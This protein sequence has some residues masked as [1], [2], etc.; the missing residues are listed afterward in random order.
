MIPV[1]TRCVRPAHRL[2]LAAPVKL[3]R[4]FAV[5][6]KSSES[7]H[8]SFAC[9]LIPLRI[10]MQRLD[11]CQGFAKLWGCRGQAGSRPP[12]TLPPDRTLASVKSSPSRSLPTPT[13]WC[14]SR[15]HYRRQED[16]RSLCGARGG[17]RLV[18]R[19]PLGQRV[20]DTS[21]LIWPGPWHR[22]P[23]MARRARTPKAFLN[24]EPT[25]ATDKR[26]DAPD[27]DCLR[28]P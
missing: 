10:G 25:P 26:A 20:S 27:A 15:F 14:T 8:R 2:S 7:I 19:D 21:G 13:A 28:E 11:S 12:D 17:S 9:F 4:Q 3:G 16:S 1:Y 24:P 22:R 5:R 23:R 6:A 18:R